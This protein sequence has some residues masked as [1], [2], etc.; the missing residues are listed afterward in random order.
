MSIQKPYSINIQSQIIDANSPFELKWIVSGSVSNAFSIEIVNNATNLIAWQLPK[1]VSFATKYIIPSGSI[2]NNNE[3]KL[4]VSIWDD[5]NL[6]TTSDYVIFQTSS[7]PNV[8]IQ[9]IGTVGSPSYVFQA[10]YQQSESV[11]M[12]SWLA[13]LY[14]AHKNRITDSGIRTSPSIEYEVKNLQSEKNYHVEFQAT[15][16]KGLTSSTGFIPFTVL[17]T[18]PQ[19]FVNLTAT[20]VP[21]KAGIQL[22]W[23]PVQVIGKKTSCATFIDNEKIDIRAKGC[24]VWFDEGFNISD[25]FTIKMWIE[26]IYKLS[27][28]FQGETI[29][30]ASA[31]PPSDLN[32]LW[33]YD[34][35]Q[36]TEKV[37]GVAAFKQQPSGVD[38]L[39]IEDSRIANEQ[40]LTPYV[41]EDVPNSNSLWI[42]TKSNI[43][44]GREPYILKL[45]GENGIY[46][47]WYERNRFHVYKDI[48]GIIS[49]FA[50]EEIQGDKFFVVF[51]QL[52]SNVDLFVETYD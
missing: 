15:S 29:I 39:W 6:S 47:M 4:R 12:R 28:G 30:I 21:E 18:R 31:L 44:D 26:D 10:S 48:S 43:N 24:K 46:K 34:P 13:I 19:V 36:L 17:Y 16:N 49:H 3:Y 38:D 37:I 52:G 1:T 35:N 20:N 9:P 45:F 51:Q 25:N 2:A 42:D 8:S 41:G 5:S 11:P 27:S 7:R 23:N 40:K 32:A 50:S 14:D 22:E 33:V